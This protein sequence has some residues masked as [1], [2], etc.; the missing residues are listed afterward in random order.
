MANRTHVIP[1]DILAVPL[2]ENLWV[3]AIVLH[4]SKQ[5][6]NGIIVGYYDRAF[7]TK[8][9][10]QQ[11]SLRVPFVWTP[12]YASVRFLT[13]GPWRI[14]GH[15]DE[16]LN[17]A[18]LPRLRVVGHLYHGDEVVSW[19]PAEQWPEYPELT[20]PGLALAEER[21]REHFE[22]SSAT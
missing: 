9:S 18:E 1:G 2:P 21:L 8:E 6:R 13:H 14:V 17:K 3:A 22:T 11:E 19:V 16:L 15:S 5:F 4:V 12:N 10:I 20:L 7:S